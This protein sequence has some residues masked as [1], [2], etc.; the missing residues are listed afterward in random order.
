MDLGGK[1]LLAWT[2][3]AAI[4]AEKVTRVVVSTEDREIADIAKKYGAE[5]PFFRSRKAA[6]DV[7]SSKMAVEEMLSG[8]AVKGYEPDAS[9]QLYPTSPFREP[10]LIDHLVGKLFSGFQQVWTVRPVTVWGIQSKSS[11]RLRMLSNMMEGA[12]RYYGLFSGVCYHKYPSFTYWLHRV[13]NPLSL[14]DIDTMDDLEL[15][16]TALGQG[17]T[18]WMYN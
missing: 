12:C 14:I 8:L 2:I 9:I 7:C 17:W 5:V 11:G 1:P 6:D 4:K 13:E 10:G 16:R 3:E 15:A 18:S